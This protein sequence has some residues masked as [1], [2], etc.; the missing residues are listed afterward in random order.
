MKLIYNENLRGISRRKI[1][2][3]EL[4]DKSLKSSKDT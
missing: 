4:T 2:K 3:E 1:F